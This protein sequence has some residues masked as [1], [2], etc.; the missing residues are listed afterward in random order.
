MSTW[1]LTKM[2]LKN[3]GNFIVP[4]C[5]GANAWIESGEWTMAA[6]TV[7][8]GYGGAA[9][10]EAGGIGAIPGGGVAGLGAIEWMG[11]KTARGIRRCK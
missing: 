10:I 1:D 11:G 7:L 4:S 6:G 8:G 5:A 3:I 2:I 9:T